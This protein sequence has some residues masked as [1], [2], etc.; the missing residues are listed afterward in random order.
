MTLPSK[1]LR[2]SP[3]AAS[4]SPIEPDLTLP[5]VTTNLGAIGMVSRDGL[6]LEVEVERWYGQPVERTRKDTITARDD[7]HMA[8]L[9][10]LLFPYGD[11]AGQLPDQ[12]WRQS[13][14]VVLV[15]SRG[16]AIV[17]IRSAKAFLDARL[18]RAAATFT[19]H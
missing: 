14:E 11:E 16:D 10:T 18:A 3:A 4:A 7:E 19:V 9:L 17:G 5:D 13:Y 6:V 15:D 1:Y 12:E 2:Q 8:R